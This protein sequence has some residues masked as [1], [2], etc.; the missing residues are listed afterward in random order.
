MLE[1]YAPQ[2]RILISVNT[3]WNLVNF[4]GGLI[5]AFIQA[6][7]EVVAVAPPD[8]YVSRLTALGCRYVPLA[9]DNQGTSIFR[10]LRLFW[11]FWWLLLNERPDVYLG[12]TIKPNTYG[13]M[14]AH[15]LHIPVINNIAGLGTAFIRGGWLAHLAKAIYRVGLS[16]SQRIFFQNADDRDLFLQ[17]GLV[18]QLQ[19]GL[20][21]G[22]G[23]NLAR[24]VPVHIPRDTTHSSSPFVFLLVARLLWDKGVGEFVAAARQVRLQEPNVR[25]QL[26]GFLDVQ[27]RSAIDRATVEAWVNEGV[28]EYLGSTDNVDPFLA[29]ADCVVLPSY[30]EGTPR[31]L[32][33]AAAMAKPLIATDVPGCR[34]VVDDGVNGLLCRER[35]ANDLA[36]KML[37]LIKMTSEARLAMGVAGRR[38]IEEEFDEQ[39]VIAAYLSEIQAIVG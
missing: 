14:A 16:R 27:N 1:S 37:T 24:Y 2:K 10:D 39:I 15:L 17:S 30:R 5:R 20:L 34:N 23:V 12:Y 18:H 38:K 8:E 11:R 31:T 6:G 26:L 36:C 33:E 4:R 22:S 13:S 9:M 21:P 3:T 28:I 19:T 29:A 7:Y 25:F 32:L 35:D